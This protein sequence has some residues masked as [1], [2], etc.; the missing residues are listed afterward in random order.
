MFCGRCCATELRMKPALPLD[1]FIEILLRASVN[2]AKRP[3]LPG[4]EL[5]CTHNLH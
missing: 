1:I 4:L 2:K 3:E 5:S